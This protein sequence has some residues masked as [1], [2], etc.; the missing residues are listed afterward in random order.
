MASWQLGKHTVIIKEESFLLFLLAIQLLMNQCVETLCM[1]LAGDYADICLASILAQEMEASRELKVSL[2]VVV[3][4]LVL[5]R[6]R[7]VMV[8]FSHFY[9]RG[10]TCQLRQY[11]AKN[12]ITLIAPFWTALPTWK[13]NGCL[14][15]SRINL[16][17][18]W[19][20]GCPFK[21]EVV[22]YNDLDLNLKI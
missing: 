12:L 11:I 7:F 3:I 9:C 21:E 6:Q 8:L 5:S 2:I 19:K 13:Y 17:L 22:E 1:L 10:R 4:D 20:G 15:V 14:G 16:S 18:P